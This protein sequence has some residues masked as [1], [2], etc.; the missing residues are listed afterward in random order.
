MALSLTITPEGGRVWRNQAFKHAGRRCPCGRPCGQLGFGQDTR[1]IPAPGEIREASPVPGSFYRPRSGIY[2]ATV[3]SVAYGKA[4]TK[5]GLML[6]N[7]ATWN[8]HIRKAKTGWEAYKVEG[9]QFQPKYSK[10]L[11]QAPY[12]SGSSFPVVWV[13]PLDGREPEDVFKQPVAPVPIPPGGGGGSAAPL[14]PAPLPGPVLPPGPV[15]P[16]PAAYPCSYRPTK[17]EIL[18]ANPRPGTFYQVRKGIYPATVAKVAYGAAN[19]KAGLMLMNRSAWN[20]HIRKGKAGWEAYKVQ[21]LQFTAHYSATDPCG[22]YGSGTAFPVVWVPFADG[23][24]PGEGPAP[25]P[26]PVPPGPVPVPPYVPPVP[27]PWPPPVPP[28]PPPPGPVPPPEPPPGPVPPPEPPPG[29]VPPP[30][31]PPGPVPP[32]PPW[33]VP[34]PPPPPVPPPVPPPA[35]TG[36]SGMG[37]FLLV[38]SGLAAL[39]KIKP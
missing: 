29:P 35:P 27:P 23:R 8:G 21:G 10:T 15:P 37:R 34:P 33:P 39:T 3:A 24:E 31:P 20:G 2:P 17:A 19:V 18:A 14:P 26:V 9:L 4:N 16:P 38:M 30:E 7:K 6:M 32:P 1:Y 11:P 36:E 5:A 25:G 28:P 12:G 22:P 13:P